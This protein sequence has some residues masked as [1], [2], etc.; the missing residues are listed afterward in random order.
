MRIV[1]IAV[2]RVKDRALRAVL[3]DA[4]RIGPLRRIASEFSFL[5]DNPNFPANIRVQ[6]TL[7]PSGCLGDLGW[8]CLRIS[9]FAMNWELP[10]SATGRILAFAA[11]G[12]TPTQFS[13]ELFFAN[14]TSAT[15]ERGCVASH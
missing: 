12:V 2:G 10:V 11:D 8:Y 5:G 14:G 15:T 3:D 1:I 4:K 9:L 13:G 7:E 6:S